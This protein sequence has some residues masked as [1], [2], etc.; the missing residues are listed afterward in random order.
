M[1]LARVTHI[2]CNERHHDE[3]ESFVWVD[4][5]MTQP[6]FEAFAKQAKDAYDKAGSDFLAANQ[7]PYV[8][9]G[10]PDYHKYPNKTVAEVKAEHEAAHHRYASWQALKKEAQA[11]FGHHLKAVGNGRILKFWEH[12]P[13]LDFELGWGHRHGTRPDLAETELKDLAG[14]IEQEEYF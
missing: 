12:K 8:S 3:P 10:A 1:K 5:A 11:D 7:P 13:S 6:E 4:Y 2:F 9:W 14:T